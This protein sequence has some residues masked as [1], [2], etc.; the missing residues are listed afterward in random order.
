MKKRAVGLF[1]SLAVVLSLLP[2]SVFAAEMPYWFSFGIKT[3]DVKNAGTDDEIHGGFTFYS[4]AP[5]EQYMDSNENDHDRNDYRYYEFAKSCS[6]PWMIEKMTLRLYGS[7]A[8]CCHYVDLFLPYIHG[9]LNHKSVGRIYVDQFLDNSASTS[10]NISQYTKRNIS[11][12]GGFDTWGGTF[13]LSEETQSTITASWNGQIEDQYGAYNALTHDDKPQF[14][15]QLSNSGV[16]DGWLSVPEVNT[17]EPWNISINKQQLIAAMASVDNQGHEGIGELV[18]D[19]YLAFPDRSTKDNETLDPVQFGN[20]TY[21]AKKKS[22]TFRRACFQ[23]GD[24]DISLTPVYIPR[25]DFNYLNREK[26]E[27][28]IRLKPTSIHCANMSDT[29]KKEIVANFSCQ[30]SLYLGNETETKLC[31]MT[32]TK[33]EDTLVFK[34]T[35]PMDVSGSL[36]DGIRLELTGVGA[37]YEDNSYTLE[38]GLDHTSFYFS[39]H[40]VDTKAPTVSITNKNGT[41][42]SIED[43]IQ[44][45]QTFY[46]VSSE[47]LYPKKDSHTDSNE[48]Y[49][50]YELYKKNGEDYAASPTQITNY[51]GSGAYAAVTAPVNTAVLQDAM[52]HLKT[53]G[54]EE[55]NYKLRIYGYDDA[56]NGL[57]GANYYEVENIYLDNMAPRVALAEEIQ[58]Q[59][60][61]GSKRNDYTFTITD[62]QTSHAHGSWARTYYCVVPNGQTMPNPDEQNATKTSGEMETVLGKWAYVEGGNETTTAIVK[63]NKGENFEGTLYYYTKDAAG[64]DSRENSGTPYFKKDIV[65]YNFDSRD[66]LQ[67]EAYEHPQSNYAISFDD[68]NNLK[69]EY[70]W[71]AEAGGDFQQN[72]QIYT[73]GMP[74]GSGTQ[75]GADGKT[76]TLDG[77]YTLEYKVT[78]LRSGNYKTFERVYVFD[79]LAPEINTK[80]LSEAQTPSD[81]QQLQVKITDVSGVKQGHYRIVNPDGSTIEEYVDT[82]FTVTQTADNRGEVKQTLTFI[83]EN[84]GVYSLLVHAEDMNGKKSDEGAEENQFCIRSEKANITQL[85]DNL[86]V[87]VGQN[88]ATADGNYALTVSVSEPMKNAIALTAQ[89][90]VH[91]CLSTDG[92]NYG[93]WMTAE[94]VKRSKTSD[95]LNYEFTLDTPQTLQKGNNTIYIKTACVPTGQTG[96]PLTSLVSEPKAITILLD[97]EAPTFKAPEYSDHSLTSENVIVSI[98]EVADEGTGVCKLES[99]DAAISVSELDG[100]EFTITVSKNVTTE[101]TLSDSLGNSVGIPIHVENIDRDAPTVTFSKETVTAGDRTDAKLTISIT[102]KAEKSTRFALVEGTA[103]TITEVD[104][105]RFEDASTFTTEQSEAQE[106]DNGTYTTT[107]TI[108]A[109]GLSGTYALGVKSEDTLGNGTEQAFEPFTLVDAIPCITEVG[110][111]PAVTKTTTNVTVKFNVPLAIIPD[112]SNFSLEYCTVR[113]NT[114][115]VTICVQ[116]E[117]GRAYELEFTP[118]ANFIEGFAIRAHIEKNGIEITNGGRIAFEENDKLYYIVKP[119]SAYEQYFY[120]DQAVYS[121]MVLNEELSEKLVEESDHMLQLDEEPGEEPADEPTEEPAEEPAGE[122]IE[123]LTRGTDSEPTEVQPKPLEEANPDRVAYKTLCFEAIRDGSPTK[124]VKFHSYTLAGNEADREQEENLMLTVDE[125]APEWKV[126]YSTTKPTNQEVTATVTLSDAESGIAKCERSQDGQNYQDIGKVT[127]TQ[128][129]FSDSGSVHY[130]ITNGAGMVTV[131][132]VTVDNIDKTPI[133][134][135]DH[136]SVVYQYQ[137][138]QNEWLPIEA[139]K[140]YREVKACIIPENASDKTIFVTNNG[141]SMTK[142]LTAEK[143]WFTFELVDE[144]GNVASKEVTYSQFDNTTGTTTWTLSNTE[145]TNQDIQAI[146]TVQDKK[147]DGIFND[148][149]FVGVKKGE[150]VYPVDGPVGDEYVVTLDSSGTYTVTACDAAGNAWTENIEVSNINKVAP[151]V[152]NTVYSTPLGEFTTKSVRVNIT[153]FSKDFESIRMTGMEPVKGT[154]LKDVEYVPGSTSVRLKKNGSVALKF[155][156]D[157]GN[158]GIYIVTVSNI[159]SLPP[160]LKANVTLAENELSVNV[161]FDKAVD[162]DGVPLDIYRELVDLQVMYGGIAYKANQAEIKLKNNG[163]YQFYVYDDSGSTQKILL[164]VTGID[165][166]APVVKEVTWKYLYHEENGT[167]IWEEKQ[168]E[169]TLQI[170]IDTSGNEAGYVIAEDENNPVT[171][172]NVEVIVKTDKETTL[173]GG[174]DAA[175]LHKSVEYGENGLYNFNMQA[176]NGM[177]ATYGVDVEVIDKTA[178]VITLDK[179]SEL[180]FIEGMNAQRNPDY[181]YDK[182]KLLDYHAYDMKNGSKIDLTEQVQISYGTGDHV[183]DPDNIENNVFSRAEPYYVEYTV[184]DT[185]GNASSIRRTICLVGFYDTIALINGV[186]PDS[187]NTAT[188]KGDTIN[189]SLKN[190]SGISYVR[191]EK[192]I[193]TQGQMKTRGTSLAQKNGVYTISNATEGWYTIYIQT[194]KRDYFNIKVYLTP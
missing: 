32:M 116:D 115:P 190:F 66:T 184:Y 131:A 146:I 99:E 188:V 181:A 182:R 180:I 29:Q 54:D 16:G 14:F 128:Y 96:A 148:I 159:C 162:E 137:N 37:S 170:G 150:T 86:K 28:T 120:V 71:S 48:N 127:T 43:S 12:V 4:G 104:Y 134:E 74:V 133:T 93:Q 103:G 7:D 179:G 78:E 139:G 64:N 185:A 60:P 169:K 121:G 51:V 143:N 108:W 94:N 77:T 8:W 193:F 31:N 63:V 130:R 156:D 10:R 25:T 142:I 175:S 165:D 135:G 46:L 15:Y 82:A 17:S 91:Y 85:K 187:T 105:T 20:K 24:E 2:M 138:Y 107:Y 88:G 33:Q 122:Q 36:N 164:E 158:E 23:L 147:M 38:S 41:P 5:V 56:N 11:S 172:Q 35:V 154:E 34:G 27:V 145:K 125:S 178:P 144:A 117:C 26:S 123:E 68:D 72:Y 57:M 53:A 153:D 6:D 160:A 39:T 65:I 40:K 21:L 47:T 189:I 113:S 163:V 62:M 132:E 92:M 183:F 9:P 136:Y 174:N 80:W 191:Y 151:E 67:T 90:D 87:R 70:R 95:Q 194:D 141:G 13:V 111:D 106:N 97:Q 59:A 83:L 42:K 177:T 18:L 81:T 109:R 129:V 157:Y 167:G 49:L 58:N 89:Q 124:S 118:N 30:A 126:Q 61:D 114:E 152:T 22:F 112:C 55:G 52:I 84:S 140:A 171:N 44:Q 192:G 45:E 110:C 161:T 173:V 3:K 186:M 155:M 168:M 101:L 166:K 76:Y 50:R 149:A 176:P 69:T 100:N 98:R 75:L 119:N 1:L 102:D 73:H 79:N 19:T